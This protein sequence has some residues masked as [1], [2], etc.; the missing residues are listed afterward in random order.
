MLRERGFK[1]IAGAS[2]IAEH[3]YV[4]KE[5]PVG[6]GRPDESDLYIALD[7]GKEIGKKI[8]NPS[9]AEIESKPLKFGNV[10]LMDKSKWPGA[11][12]MAMLSVP[13]YDEEKCTQCNNC[14]EVCPVEA[15]DTNYSTNSEKCIRCM[16]CIKFCPTK[17][18]AISF[19]PKLT[20]FMNSWDKKRKEPILYI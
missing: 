9:E 7:L 6:I 10:H 8:E 13:K 11:R 2:F 3:S 15:V 4:H 1:I 17:A 14:V 18:K 5:A 12:T 19:P 16:A 20:E